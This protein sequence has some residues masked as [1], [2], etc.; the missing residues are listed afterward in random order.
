MGLKMK[1]EYDVPKDEDDVP[2][3]E[4]DVPKDEYSTSFG[5]ISDMTLI[6]YVPVMMS[7]QTI[8]HLYAHSRIEEEY[9][10]ALGFSSLYRDRLQKLS[11]KEEVQRLTSTWMTNA[12][13]V[14]YFMNIFSIVLIHFLG[15]A[16]GRKIGMLVS[17][18]GTIGKVIV[19][20][21]TMSFKLPLNLL[22][23]ACAM[24]GITGGAGSFITGIVSHISDESKLGKSCFDRFSRV[25]ALAVGISGIFIIIFGFIITTRNSIIVSLCLLNLTL[26]SGIILIFRFEESQQRNTS[27][28]YLTM[29]SSFWDLWNVVPVRKFLLLFFFLSMAAFSYLP[30]GGQTI[31]IT[32]FFINKSFNSCDNTTI[33]IYLGI[34]TFSFYITYFFASMAT[35]EQ[36]S[37][38]AIIIGCLLIGFVSSIVLSLTMRMF[39]YQAV[40]VNNVVVYTVMYFIGKEMSLLVEVRLHGCLY[41]LLFIINSFATSLTL[42]FLN[43]IYKRT[44][45]YFPGS[46][47]FTYAAFFLIAAAFQLG[48]WFYEKDKKEKRE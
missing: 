26:I 48:V 1:Q 13:S 15:E 14:E 39:F 45:T 47:Y 5:Q 19:I 3:D 44:L 29:K 38:N 16:F 27:Q 10:E 8:M 6:C 36:I 11:I 24:N 46:L 31:F 35:M 33:G 42:P 7:C 40:L 23:V 43:M 30:A 25:L 17:L 9:S 34:F 18:S 21:A 28:I 37:S 20:T 32:Q 41:A 4:D 12:L 22:V 2:K